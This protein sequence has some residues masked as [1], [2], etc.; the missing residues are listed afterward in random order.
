LAFPSNN[1]ANTQELFSTYTTPEDNFSLPNRID[2]Q[3]SIESNE[4]NIIMFSNQPY[5][6]N[7]DWDQFMTSN[8][9]LDRSPSQRPTHYE[10]S[11]N[12]DVSV[13]T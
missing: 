13:A 10:T 1:A 3:H 4:G 12:G 2:A 11:E 6:Y 8:E 5:V 7:P 9:N